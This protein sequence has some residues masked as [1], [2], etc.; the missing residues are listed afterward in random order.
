VTRTN[1]ISLPEPI[2]VADKEITAITTQTVET[3]NPIQPVV[4]EIQPKPVIPEPTETKTATTPND[5]TT[6][7]TSIL[8]KE[9]DYTWDWEKIWE[10]IIAYL[11]KYWN[12][13]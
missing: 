12:K 6:T 13:P 7:V 11:D 8:D 5:E 4:S 10:W 1:T 9:L 2:K 3:F